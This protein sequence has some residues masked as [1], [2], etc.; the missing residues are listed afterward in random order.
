MG[1]GAGESLLLLPAGCDLVVRPRFQCLL[2]TLRLAGMSVPESPPLICV[3]K[4][5]IPSQSVQ[6]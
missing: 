4:C 1:L 5:V 6:L 2:L 3:F